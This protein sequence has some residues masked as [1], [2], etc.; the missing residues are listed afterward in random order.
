MLSTWENMFSKTSSLFNM[1][2]DGKFSL[3]SEDVIKREKLPKLI[4]KM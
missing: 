4:A 2:F 1:L 3:V